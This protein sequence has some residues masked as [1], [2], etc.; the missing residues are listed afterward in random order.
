MDQARSANAAI[1][2][3][4]HAAFARRHHL[5]ILKAERARQAQAARAAAGPL[6]AVRVRRVF[7]QRQAMF[8]GQRRQPV[9]I[10]DGAAEVHGDDGLCPP[11]DGRGGAFRVHVEA[12][13]LDVHEDRRGAH[14][15]YRHGRRDERNGR[16]NHLVARTHGRRAQRHLQ[17]DRAVH[18]RDGVRAMRERGELALQP[19]D[20]IAVPAP[21][22]AVQHFAQQFDFAIVSK[23]ASWVSAFTSPLRCPAG[24]S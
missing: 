24:N 16:H 19:L 2:G 15:R 20:E 23:P 13:R 17:R 12:Q 8:G 11:R 7:D 18:G 5:R 4:Q 9:H 10:R 22:P 3:G 14:A 21:A 6:R 1:V